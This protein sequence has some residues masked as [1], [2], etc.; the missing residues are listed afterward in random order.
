MPSR[1]TLESLR[2]QI[3]AIE[4]GSSKT[5]GPDSI[6]RQL[7]LNT[8]T[9]TT[10]VQE[11][12]TQLSNDGSVR[13]NLGEVQAEVDVAFKKILA[14]LNASD[15]PEKAIR[16]RLGESGFTQDAI[17]EAVAKAK[18]FGFIDDARYAEVLMRSRLAQGKGSAGIERELAANNIDVFSVEGWPDSFGVNEESE[19]ERALGYLERKPPRSKNQRE[20]AFRKLVS[21][22]YS[23]SVASKAARI[24]HESTRS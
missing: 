22:G 11:L 4:S 3:C 15:K 19:L 8:N 21:K 23:S 17:N 24:W 18:D 14:I 9:A 6:E 10:S 1:K 20:A 13:P 12:V 7:G 2:A 5:V 16:E